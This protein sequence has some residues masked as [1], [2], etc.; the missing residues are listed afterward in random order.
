[1]D[2]IFKESLAYRLADAL[3]TAG[4]RWKHEQVY[5]RIFT[6]KTALEQFDMRIVRLVCRV[7]I[8]KLDSA[9]IRAGIQYPGCEF[10]FAIDF[11]SLGQPTDCLDSSSFDEFG[12]TLSNCPHQ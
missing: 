5:A 11:N 2:I 8:A 9:E 1:M 3:F 10:S 7:A 12:C 4:I 6:H